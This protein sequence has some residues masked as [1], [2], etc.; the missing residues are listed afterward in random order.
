MRYSTNYFLRKFLGA[1]SVSR[2][3]VTFFVGLLPLGFCLLPILETWLGQRDFPMIWA[4]F[5]LAFY[6]FLRFSEFTYH[7]V[8]SFRPQFDTW[9]PIVCHFIRVWYVRRT[10]LLR[11]GRLKQ[12]SLTRVSQSL[13]PKPLVPCALYQLCS[14]FSSPRTLPAALFS[15]VGFLPTPR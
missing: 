10:S 7:G 12:T 2:A 11:S 6:G 4:T 9:V 5:T 13:L 3:N 15:R 1:S 8:N 14:S